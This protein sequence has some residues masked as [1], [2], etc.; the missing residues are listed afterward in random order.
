MEQIVKLEA[1]ATGKPAQKI[2]PVPD[3][4]VKGENN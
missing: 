1:Q 2:H 3:A 4:A